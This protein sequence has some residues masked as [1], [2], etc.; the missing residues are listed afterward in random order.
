MERITMDLR[1]RTVLLGLLL[2]AAAPGPAQAQVEEARPVKV[3]R[4]KP[5]KV[6]LPTLRFLRENRDF[7]R[8]RMDALE[9][10]LLE[11]QSQAVP[12]DERFM[13]F[14][15]MLAALNAARDTVS[16]AQR[17]EEQREFLAS[18]TE[19]GELEEELDLLEG[20]LADQE[21]RIREL[22]EDFLE[23]QE[24]ALVIVMRG[25]PGN[26]VP[27]A[28][29]LTDETG[30]TVRTS[31]TEEDRV[32]LGGGGIAQIYHEF[33]EPRYQTWELALLGEDGGASA[34]AYLSLEPE[35][36]QLN[37]LELDLAGISEEE[38]PFGIRA[39]AWVQRTVSPPAVPEGPAVQ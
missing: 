3:E 30:E 38:G 14:Q 31:L 8:G 35:R 32:S 27:E 10:V 26:A 4:A 20:L 2:V 33:V 16:A 12:M 17:A 24:T 19:L 15:E 1:A 23:R 25:W 29:L 9:Q 13:R 39:R 37:F 21:V 6:K 7:L 36:N 11:A 22:E 28:I 18:V 34:P 5:D